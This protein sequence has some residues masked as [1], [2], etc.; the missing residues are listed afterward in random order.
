LGAAAPLA[1]LFQTGY[2]RKE[3]KEGNTRGS[4]RTAKAGERERHKTKKEA[5]AKPEAKHS[6]CVY[7]SFSTA[8]CLSRN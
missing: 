3:K 1:F 2:A 6:A 7:M 8:A 4:R 5:L